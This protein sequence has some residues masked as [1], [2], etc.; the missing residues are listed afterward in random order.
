MYNFLGPACISVQ[1]CMGILPVNYALDLR[2]FNF[3][4]KQSVHHIR[5]GLLGA[6]FLFSLIG[7]K[8]F[9]LLCNRLFLNLINGFIVVSAC[10]WNA[11]F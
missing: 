10:V 3:L 2:K 6:L 7:S 1:Y 8:E 4:Q 5:L 9:E 11:F